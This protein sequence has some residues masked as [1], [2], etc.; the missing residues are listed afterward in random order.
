MS[1]IFEDAF[2]EMHDIKH[3]KQSSIRMTR[4]SKSL[5]SMYGNS[6]IP[7]FRAPPVM[8]TTEWHK[9]YILHSARVCAIRRITSKYHKVPRQAAPQPRIVPCFPK[10]GLPAAAI[11]MLETVPRGT[12]QL[13]SCS[14]AAV[15]IRSME[16]TNGSAKRSHSRQRPAA[17]PVSIYRHDRHVEA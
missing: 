2:T 15:W 17:E 11:N 14:P 10:W 16:S 12:M 3:C 13:G 1:S 6:L 5:P 7:T 4:A 9:K 8:G